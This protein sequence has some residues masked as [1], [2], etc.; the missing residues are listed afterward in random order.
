M[1]KNILS[2]LLCYIIIFAPNIVKAEE[3]ELAEGQIVSIQQG[4]PAPFAGVLL[5]PI[6]A[7]K[8]NT[9]KKYSLLEN[10]LK[11]EYETKKLTADYELKLGLLQ[12]RYDSL[13]ISTDTT[14][15]YKNEEINRLQDLVKED[16]NDYTHWWLFGG[17]AI[18]ILTS[19]GIFY[20]SVDATK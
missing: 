10:S 15:L 12:T 2:L 8:I 9:D 11:L 6:A 13:K 7:A 1:R 18:G 20:A 3:T 17:I 5:D 19:I 14:L 4:A 16:P